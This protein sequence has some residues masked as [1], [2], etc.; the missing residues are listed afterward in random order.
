MV[1]TTVT[2]DGMACGMCEAH[3][4][5][6]IRLEFEVKAVSS[7]H[8]TGKTEIVSM[9]VLDEARLRECIANDG[10]RVISII[11]EEFVEPKKK[12]FFSLFSKK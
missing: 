5:N 9:T 6:C 7:S 1:K 3:V 10:Y 2:I 8:K 4:N 12:G 11:S